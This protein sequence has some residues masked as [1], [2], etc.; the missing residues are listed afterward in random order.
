MGIPSYFSYIVKNHSQIIQKLNHLKVENNCF[1]NLYL[2]CNSII[3]DAVHNIDFS[4]L[5]ESDVKTIIR[6]VFTKIEEYIL[7]IKPNKNI[8]IAFDGVAPVAKLDQQRERRYKSLYQTEIS[9]TIFKN[10]KTDVWNTAAITPGTKFMK[11]LSVSS[12]KYFKDPS[13]YGVQKI[14]VS[15]SEE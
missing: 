15:T 4:S 6:Y 3:Y 9:K 2:D 13:K 10:A 5:N 8:Y 14:I 11:E 7:I 1:D 12:R